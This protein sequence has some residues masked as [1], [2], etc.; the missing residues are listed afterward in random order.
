[1]TSQRHPL[2]PSCRGACLALL[3]V[4]CAGR[5]PA[6][7]EEKRLEAGTCLARGDA[8]LSRE[9]PDR[10]WHVVAAGKPVWTRDELL[11]LPGARAE[12]LSKD[13]AV[14]LSLWGNLPE[15]APVP[16]LESA[17]VLHD[18][19][20]ADLDLTLLRG[21]LLFRNRKDKGAAR[22]LLH[23]DG[24]A[25]ELTLVD[26]ESEAAVELSGRWPRG[27]GFQLKP[28][29]ANR[30]I[31]ALEL[32]VLKGDV[33]LRFGGRRFGLSAPP[34]PAGFAWNS[35]AGPAPGP[36]KRERVPDWADPKRP[37]G[38]DGKRMLAV[39]EQLD[40][41][42]AK[43][44]PPAAL[45]KLS[46]AL[47]RSPSQREAAAGRML[48]VYCLGA[49]DDLPGLIK[50]LGDPRHPEVRDTAVD[51]LR[52]WIGR[53]PGQDLALYDFLVKH[54]KYAPTLA[55]T[56][57]QLLHSPFDDRLPETYEALI[58][59]LRHEKLPIRELARWHLQRLAPKI[60]IPYDAAASPEERE[61]AY[62]EWKKRIPDG[63]LP[64]R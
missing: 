12:V 60:D 32:N 6:A 50:A 23:F 42:L 63:K 13:G 55:E 36:Q 59:Y 22:V 61:K 28:D 43:A 62:Q 46:E 26:R 51:T 16:L 10:D 21:R 8:L 24:Q 52:A 14:Q 40:G 47:D 57:L 17:V 19:G 34:G 41:Y 31:T 20:A 49:L 53:G 27:A 25:W 56:L 54:E 1:M 30:P 15:L 9:G 48:V 7:P 39:L 2:S 37:A 58:G 18:P 4:V 35:L 44:P 64:P 33:D 45:P 29:P 5:S 38:A 11:A 3:A